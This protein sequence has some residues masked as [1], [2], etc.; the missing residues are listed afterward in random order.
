M[1]DPIL[2]VDVS[3]IHPGHLEAVKELIAELVAFADANEPQLIAYDFFIDESN[4]TMTCVAL[5]PDS[6]SME[7]HMDV[8]WELFRQFSDHIEQR[9]IDVY[10]DAGET[11]LA[12][13]HQK[14]KM[15]GKGT[16]N[17]HVLQAGFVRMGPDAA[18]GY[19]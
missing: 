15:L 7:F 9:S 17:A 5:H 2:Y 14:I 18:S 3:D 10:G 6:D 11:V 12:R 8:G 19:H 4:S 1:S 16:V 13:L